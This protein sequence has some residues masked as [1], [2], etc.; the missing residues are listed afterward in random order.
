M[1]TLQTT[2]HKTWCKTRATDDMN[3]LKIPGLLFLGKLKIRSK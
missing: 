2:L 1:T 3:A